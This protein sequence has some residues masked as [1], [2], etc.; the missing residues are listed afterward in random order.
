MA[1][2]PDE[3]LQLAM[4]LSEKI[5]NRRPE[6]QKA[7]RYFRGEEGRLR[8]ASDEFKEYFSRRFEGFSDNWC[9]PVAQAPI[10]RIKY[11]GI[12]LASVE[13][14]STRP[15]PA[16]WSADPVSERAW[17]RSDAHRMLS[18][19][20]L[21]MTIGKRSF[22]LVSQ[23]PQ[24][25]RITFE[26]PDSA[27]VAY[28]GA[29]HQRLAG[30]TLWADDTAEYGE[31]L[32]PRSVLSLKRKKVAVDRGER[33]VPPD[34]QDW[35]FRQGANGTVERT[36]PF[37]VV[38][39]VEMRNQSLL[40]NDPISDIGLVM[41]TQD[42]VNLVWAYTLNAL[43][44][45]SLPGRVVMNGEIPKEPVLNEVGEKIGERPMELDSLI[46]D[47]VA[48]LQGQGITIGEWSKASVDG[49]RDIIE[50]A[51]SHIA[52]QTR[53]PSHY[54]LSA[55][56]NVP[57]T[58]Y[59]LAEAGLVSKAT[60]RIGFANAPVKEVN[61]L[62]AIADGDIDRAQRIAEGTVLWGKP[63]YRSESQLMDGL[64]KMRTTGFPMRWIAEEYGLSPEE[65]DRVME[66]VREE[67]TDPY[68]AM[69]V[70]GQDAGAE[71]APVG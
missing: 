3:V 63:Q 35:E 68:L 45:L 34:A 23:T 47:R 19:A 44:Y 43:D 4:L 31:L 40:D 5:R 57:A 69:K 30:M 32:L 13:G 39:L 55:K 38:P 8:F 33:Y 25:S 11:L 26:N 20:V 67:Q 50:L 36:H 60:E 2:T 54:L 53:T 18:E 22:G 37:G 52:A 51:V 64:A 6:V 41:P 58:G 9:M 10:E 1:P 49:F 46:R 29:T 66:M 65:V 16:R 14:E 59:D 48:W 15:G 21:M 71:P 7:G 42:T 12:R 27:A 24:G 61:R 62:A 56:D 17:E 28:D 70:D